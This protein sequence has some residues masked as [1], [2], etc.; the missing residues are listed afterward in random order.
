MK[1]T[2]FDTKK[3]KSGIVNV[4]KAVARIQKLREAREEQYP[5]RVL[6]VNERTILTNDKSFFK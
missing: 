6:R 1:K 4:A 3:V 2:S 5:A